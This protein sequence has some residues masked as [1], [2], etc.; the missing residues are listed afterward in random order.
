MREDSNEYEKFTY[1]TLTLKNLAS[2]ISRGR[3]LNE[4]FIRSLLKTFSPEVPKS[5]EHER[6]Y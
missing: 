6:V 5:S 3:F 1:L 2:N 4:V